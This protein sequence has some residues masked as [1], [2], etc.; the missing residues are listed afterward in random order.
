MRRWW[1]RAEQYQVPQR[2]LAASC[3][4]VDVVGVE[5]PPVLAAREA[6]AAVAAPERSTQG[7]RNR[8][9]LP[10]DR[11]RLAVTLLQLDHGGIAGKPPGGFRRER[12]PLAEL[13]APLSACERRLVDVHDDLMPVAA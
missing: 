4:V 1:R 3:P 11:E 10:P 13:A 6:A 8:A 7:G 2:R 5:E 9:C 12:R